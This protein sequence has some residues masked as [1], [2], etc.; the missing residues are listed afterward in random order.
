MVEGV[1]K[2]V[3]REKRREVLDGKWLLFFVFILCALMHCGLGMA[4]V[5]W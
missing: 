2:G 4:W 3:I 1:G 5:E